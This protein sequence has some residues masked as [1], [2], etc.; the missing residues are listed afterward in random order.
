MNEELAARFRPVAPPRVIEGAYT[1]DQHRA[2]ARGGAR[3]RPSDPFTDKAF[4]R[5]LNRV[6]DLGT[7]T[8]MPPEP[9]EEPVAA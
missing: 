7:P 5:L 8:I 1:D 2:P 4:I 3:A 6:Y 9:V